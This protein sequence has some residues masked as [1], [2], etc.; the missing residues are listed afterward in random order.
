MLND[1]SW[2]SDFYNFTQEE[3]ITVHST[4][5]PFIFFLMWLN[6]FLTTGGNLVTIIAFLRDKNIYSKPGNM[7]ILNL[8]FADLK[9]G[10]VSLPWFNLWLH[11][12][13]WIFGEHLCK[14]WVIIDYAATIESMLAMLLISWDRLFM[15]ESIQNTFETKRKTG[16]FRSL[17][18][19][20]FYAT[21]FLCLQCYYVPTAFA[22]FTEYLLWLNSVINPFLY[23]ATNPL[24]RKQLKKMFSCRQHD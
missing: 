16:L 5:H 21:L 10:L 17:S 23:V 3:N 22:S 20:G 11:Y 6:V 4:L 9:V 12:G 24:F 7:L 1:T 19:H 18:L 15:V 8:A 2:I 13:D 14:W